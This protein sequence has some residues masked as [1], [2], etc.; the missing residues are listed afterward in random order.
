MLPYSRALVQWSS[1]HVYN[2]HWISS[3]VAALQIR[4]EKESGAM[5][6]LARYKPEAGSGQ[7]R[8]ETREEN[9]PDKSHLKECR[10]SE[11]DSSQHHFAAGMCMCS[12]R[13]V[14]SQF[15]CVLTPMQ[16]TWY[17]DDVLSLIVSPA[18]CDIIVATDN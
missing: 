14:T 9:L 6:L 1:S 12:F 3:G 15:H 2:V 5:K 13:C 11:R 18:V 7:S 8:S 16:R 10:F 17:A 4:R